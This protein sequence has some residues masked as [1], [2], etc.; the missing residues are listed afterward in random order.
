MIRTND[1]NPS[2]VECLAQCITV[3][4]GL[5]GRI[6][7]DTSAQGR[8]VPIVEVEMRHSGFCG[9]IRALRQA[10][11]PCTHRQAQGSCR[12]QFQFFCRCKMGN[13]ETSIMFLSQFYSQFGALI[14]ASSLRIS[15]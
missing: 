2:I 6:A 14:T 11:G 1:S 8:I 5:N 7:L 4:L 15:G 9:D 3:S 13:M 12:E 10:Q